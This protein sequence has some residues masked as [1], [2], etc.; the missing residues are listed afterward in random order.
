MLFNQKIGPPRPVFCLMRN[1]WVFKE[2]CVV[3]VIIWYFQE[4]LNSS[5]GVEC[6]EPG[7]FLQE[8]GGWRT[9][10][11]VLALQI[12]RV[13]R[14]RGRFREMEWRDLQ[15]SP[16]LCLSEEWVV[17]IATIVTIVTIVPMVGGQHQWYSSKMLVFA[18]SLRC[19]FLFLTW[20][21]QWLSHVH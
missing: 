7:C 11:P 6:S 16:L 13:C 12:R 2:S 19:Y 15:L 18:R 5:L 21:V 20:R 8:L 10:Q 9:Q 1:C 17:T 3:M 4:H 14:N